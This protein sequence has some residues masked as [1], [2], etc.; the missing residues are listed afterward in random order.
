MKRTGGLAAAAAFV[1]VSLA[2]QFHL[3]LEHLAAKASDSVDLSLS[4][5]TLQFAAR[6]LDGK[7]PDEARVKKLISG[8]N[9]IYLKSF[10]F[11]KEGVWTQ[12][13]LDRVRN[14][15]RAP[16][17][18]RI[19]A[20]KSAEEG[21]TAEVYLRTENK[22]VTGVAILAFEPK[23]LTVVNIAGSVDLDSLAELGGHL[24][25]PKVRK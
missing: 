4:G 1:A 20:F 14:Q 9:G 25:L 13:D 23:E 12:A 11:K 18:E 2:Q 17:W 22:K 10:E 15:L 7:D 21:E 8:L 6:F 3:D 16:E 5:A 24:G 19:V